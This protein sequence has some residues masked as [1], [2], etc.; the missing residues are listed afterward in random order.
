MQT[1]RINYTPLEE[2]IENGTMVFSR[3][4]LEQEKTAKFDNVM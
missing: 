1:E 2:P 3:N 4:K